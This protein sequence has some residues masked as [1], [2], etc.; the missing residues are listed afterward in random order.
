MAPKKY[1]LTDEHRAQLPVWRDCWIANA[2]RTGLMDTAEK[3]RI[4]RAIAGLYAAANLPRPRIVFVPSPFVARFA[5]GFAAAIWYLRN[6]K[7]PVNTDAATEAA[8]WAATRAATEDATD[9]ATRAA[10]EDATRAAIGAA[11]RAATEDATRAATGAATEAATWDATR[12]ATWDATRAATEAATGAATWA[13]T[14]NKWYQFPTNTMRLLAFTLSPQH[15][16]LFIQCASHAY[17]MWNGGNQWS[18]RPAY[19]SFFR[20]IAKLAID[21]TKWNHYEMA[22]QAGPRIMHREFCLVSE[23]PV[24]LHV[25]TQNRPHCATGP[26]CRWVD[27]SALFALNGVYVPAWVVLTPVE[28]IDPARI[29]AETNA[30]VRAE[31]IRKVGI[32]RFIQ[33]VGATV[34]DTVGDYQLL[35]V[36]YGDGTKRPYLKMRNPSV[37]IWHVEGV[38]PGITTVRKALQW[39]KPKRLQSIPVDEKHGAE[40]YQQGD[41]CVWP[42]SAKSI[43]SEPTILT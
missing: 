15:N 19:L 16:N 1:T 26:F 42:K 23:R 5:G 32:E 22:A 10:T 17:T 33:K 35:A 40:W 4:T 34:L 25:D 31:I 24:E 8:T 11:T 37:G 14:G 21:Y 13:A 6:N 3:Q 18:G 36:D 27:G 12:A 39:R 2:F 41:V 29:L 30:Q 7:I 43:K 9:A 28:Q 20:Y 38:Q